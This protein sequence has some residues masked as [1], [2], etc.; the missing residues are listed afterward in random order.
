V[1]FGILVVL[2]DLVCQQPPQGVDELGRRLIDSWSS[3]Q[4]KVID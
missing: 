2:Q 1:D 3:T 4:Q